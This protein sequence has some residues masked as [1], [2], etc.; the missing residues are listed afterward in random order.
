MSWLTWLF[1]LILLAAAGGAAFLA[2]RTYMFGDAGLKVGS[3][4]F[5]QRAEPRLGVVEQASVDGRRRLV[6]VR[7]DNVEHLIMTGG[8]VDVVIENNIRAPA[9][10]HSAEA[11]AEQS[12]P[13]FTRQPR[14]FGQAVNE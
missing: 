6:L 1:I 10:E 7:R 9:V 2:Y 11:A 5:K 13:V 3:W 4:L 14:S 8:P 12:P